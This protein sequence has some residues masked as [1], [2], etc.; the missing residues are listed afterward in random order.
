MPRRWAG[1][2]DGRG[3]V[4]GRGPR[5][6]RWTAA[7]PAATLPPVTAGQ[8]GEDGVPSSGGASVAALVEEARNGSRRAQETLFRRYARMAYGLAHRL[9]PGD[10]DAE[11][12]V[13]D[14][15]VEALI[16][17][18]R[19]ERPQAFG[20]WLGSIVVR[21]A[22]KRLRRRRLMTRVGLRRNEPVDVERFLSASVPPDVAAELRALY[23][24]LHELP[25]DARVAVVLRRVEGMTIA[26]TAEVMG[27]STATVKRRIQDVDALLAA[28]FPDP[29]DTGTRRTGHVAGAGAPSAS[30]QGDDGM[31]DSQPPREATG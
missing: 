11:D 24:L 20:S 25:P 6:R 21:T 4:P 30:K 27:I 31:G 29:S 28:R 15:Y 10:P 26:E 14:A 8:E 2:G 1:R 19:L 23:G 13:Q 5:P 9:M 16:H 7:E 17:L 18:D 12:L 22:H 3:G